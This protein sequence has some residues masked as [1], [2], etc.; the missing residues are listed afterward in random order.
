MTE[1]MQRNQGVGFRVLGFGYETL[2]QL[3]S[4]NKQIRIHWT[5]TRDTLHREPHTLHHVSE[6]YHCDK[7]TTKFSPLVTPERAFDGFFLPVMTSW[8]TTTQFSI[9]SP[10]RM[11]TR[12]P[13]IARRTVAPPSTMTSSHRIESRTSAPESMAAFRPA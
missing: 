9:T 7:E 8:R 11:R 2:R 13:R 4:A 3:S 10:W 5:E 12:S 6:S 1:L